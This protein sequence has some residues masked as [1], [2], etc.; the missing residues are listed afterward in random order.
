MD[1]TS[2]FQIGLRAAVWCFSFFFFSFFFSF[3]LFPVYSRSGWKPKGAKNAH[4]FLWL[5]FLW[6]YNTWSH[7][8]SSRSSSLLQCK[9]EPSKLKIS[10]LDFLFNCSRNL[11][12]SKAPQHWLLQ[13]A[14]TSWAP[15]HLWTPVQLQGSA[16][17]CTAVSGTS[18]F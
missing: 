15:S 14:Q 5:L 3:W 13:P 16:V 17:S 2:A 9:L 6:F 11:G 12:S 7:R 8:W 18:P 1:G 4:S 10:P